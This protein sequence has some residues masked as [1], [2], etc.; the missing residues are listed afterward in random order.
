MLKLSYSDNSKRSRENSV[1]VIVLLH[2]IISTVPHFVWLLRFF[3]LF[4][5]NFFLEQF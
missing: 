2:V 5:D 1:V 4:K 3:S